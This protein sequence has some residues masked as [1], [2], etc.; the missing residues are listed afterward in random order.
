MAMRYIGNAVITIKYTGCICGKDTYTGTISADGNVWHFD[1]LHAPAAGFCFAY[2]SPKAYDKM[3][4]SAVSFGSY[5]TTDNRGDELPD[6]A[7]PPDVADAISSAT[8][9]ALRD[10]GTYKV[11][12][13]PQ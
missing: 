5:Y 9:W 4:E 3:A 1:T 7:P 11:R 12:R 8:C 10:N 13:H 2:D 6:W